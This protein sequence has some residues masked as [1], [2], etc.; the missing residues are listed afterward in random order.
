MR[1]RFTKDELAIVSYPCNQFGKQ[2]PGTSA[3]ILKFA[4]EH[5]YPSDAILMRK[6]EVNGKNEDE[7]WTLLKRKFGNKNVFWNFE[8]FLVDQQGVPIKRYSSQWS[9]DIENDIAKLLLEND[10]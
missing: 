4:K 1:K 9:N 5:E 3:E 7:N 10:L 6:V 2:E 8:K